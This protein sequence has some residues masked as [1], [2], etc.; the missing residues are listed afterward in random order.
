MRDIMGPPDFNERFA[1]CPP[2]DGFMDLV[3]RELGLSAEP[4]ATRLAAL[5]ALRSPRR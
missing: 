3:G 4:D 5:G 1:R 2:R